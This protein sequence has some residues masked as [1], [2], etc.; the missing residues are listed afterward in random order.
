MKLSDIARLAGVSVTTASYVINGKAEQQRISPATV[1]RVRA[2]VEQ[3]DF[4]PNPQA[5]GLRSRHSRTLGFILPD[6]ENP[7]YA[8]IAKL[9]EQGAR[10]RG[11]QLLVASS[12]DDP[13]SELQL[14]Q[15][16]RARRCDALLVASGLPASDDS[17]RQ[18]QSQG[19]PIIA[20]DREMDREL[21]CSVVSDDQQASQQLTQSLLKTRP[22]HIALIGARPELSVSRERAA[23]FSQALEGFSGQVIIEQ[24]DAFSRACGQRLTEELLQRL[25]HLPDALVTT[26]YVLLQGVFDALPR[27][28]TPHLGTFGDTQLLDFLPLPV[29]AMAQQ[30]QLIADKALELALSAIEQEHYQPG[31]HAIPRTFK[32]R[33]GEV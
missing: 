23:G 31:V 14:L 1:E 27:H 30:H 10:A 13:L 2:V 7:S 28:A 22:Q 15:L 25:G 4:R 24:G 20:I 3:H 21:F 8:R 5:A 19:I 16:F 33:I 32:Q 29:N 12:D 6:L 17:Y 26:S 9:L 11:Y 18:L